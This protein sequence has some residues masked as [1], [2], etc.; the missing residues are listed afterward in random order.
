[1]VDRAF[2][3]CTALEWYTLHDHSVP[4]ADQESS[5]RHHIVLWLHFN[6]NNCF[7]RS[8][9][10]VCCEL[11][12]YKRKTIRGG[13][14]T[15]TS[16]DASGS[17][18]WHASCFILDTYVHDSPRL[19]LNFSNYFNAEYYCYNVEAL[20]LLFWYVKDPIHIRCLFV[21]IVL[22]VNCKGQSILA[23]E[24]GIFAVVDTSTIKSYGHQFLPNLAQSSSLES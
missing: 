24:C 2:A 12:T 22:T 6:I 15:T 19:H 10:R 3:A 11:E 9:D 21:A 13:N 14:K 1:M 17:R 18:V 23:K 7:Y 16:S 20:L 8:A 5:Y 4:M